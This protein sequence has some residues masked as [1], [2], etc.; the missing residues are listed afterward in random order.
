MLYSGEEGEL[1][2]HPKG[3]GP[4]LDGILRGPP[5]HLTTQF[6]HRSP[7]GPFCGLFGSSPTTSV[8]SHPVAP[9]RRQMAHCPGKLPNRTRNLHKMIIS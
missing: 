9:S 1:V 2:V 5:R 3:L 8:T 4:P 7:R 6:V